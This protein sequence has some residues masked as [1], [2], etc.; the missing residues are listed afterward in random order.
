MAV[1]PYALEVTN[2]V[3]NGVICDADGFDFVTQLGA[4]LA[5]RTIGYLLGIP[6]SDQQVDANH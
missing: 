3:G 4:V 2:S 5:M 1:D 6:E